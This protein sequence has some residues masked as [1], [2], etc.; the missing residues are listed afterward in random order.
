MH[1]LLEIVIQ[2]GK[3]FPNETSTSCRRKVWGREKLTFQFE[4]GVDLFILRTSST[5]R[6]IITRRVN[7]T[8]NTPTIATI[9]VYY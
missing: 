3:D 4:Q 8:S 5:A 9:T 7:N 1:I 2:T 6:N